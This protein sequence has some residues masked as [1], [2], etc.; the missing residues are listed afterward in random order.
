V[1]SAFNVI[2]GDVLLSQSDSWGRLQVDEFSL[3]VLHDDGLFAVKCE[4]TEGG[5]SVFGRGV[6]VE[7]DFLSFDVNF[8]ARNSG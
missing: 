4:V 8:R 7:M 1:L 3:I 5:R 2:L 6:A